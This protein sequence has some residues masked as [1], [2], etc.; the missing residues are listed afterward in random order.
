MLG[1]LRA[2]AKPMEYKSTCT[3]SVCQ[4][5]KGTA[6]RIQ[7]GDKFTKQSDAHCLFSNMEE[8]VNQASDDLRRIYKLFTLILI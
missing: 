6:V 1:T 4:R 5:A 3:L 8:F 2:C 7:D